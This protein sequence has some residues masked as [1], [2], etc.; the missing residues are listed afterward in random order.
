MHAIGIPSFGP[1]GRVRKP[2]ERLPEAL[3][4]TEVEEER[5]SA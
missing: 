2:A 3:F 5:G 1:L 4:S